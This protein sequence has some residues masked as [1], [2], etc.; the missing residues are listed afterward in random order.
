[1][2]T[3]DEDVDPSQGPPV[4][5]TV[6][7]DP[8]VLLGPGPRSWA[9]GELPAEVDIVLG[10]P[11]DGVLDIDITASTC[12]GDLCTIHRRGEERPLQVR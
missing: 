11:G 4:R 12:R 9:L 6:S 1:V 5:V 3:A 8:A 7:A 10:E 2:D